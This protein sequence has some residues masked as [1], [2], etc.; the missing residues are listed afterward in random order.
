MPL[1][2]TREDKRLTAYSGQVLLENS[3]GNLR[4]FCGGVGLLGLFVLALAELS[5]AAEILNGMATGGTAVLLVHLGKFL[6]FGCALW[7][8]FRPWRDNSEANAKECRLRKAMQAKVG[9]NPDWRQ[10]RAEEQRERN[11][12]RENLEEEL[13]AMGYRPDPEFWQKALHRSDGSLAELTRQI[14]SIRDSKAEKP[15]I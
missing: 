8:F 15:S 5:K 3:I 11:E 9:A 13:A 2:S 1:S 6:F 7:G 10:R 4:V 14:R 12:E